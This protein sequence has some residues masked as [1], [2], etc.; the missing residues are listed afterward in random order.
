MMSCACACFMV[1]RPQQIFFL[2]I[3]VVL[4]GYSAA[5]WPGLWPLRPYLGFGATSAPTFNFRSLL[6]YLGFFAL[7]FTLSQTTA[8]VGAAL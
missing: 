2:L 3:T 8:V 1:Q 4:L 6:G 5:G 7:T